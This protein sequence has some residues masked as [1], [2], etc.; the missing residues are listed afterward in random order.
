MLDD[1]DSVNKTL[2]LIWLYSVGGKQQANEINIKTRGW[3]SKLFPRF[4][5]SSL[6][7]SFWKTIGGEVQGGEENECEES[8]KDIWDS[9]QE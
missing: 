1:F 2:P 3:I 8:K 7:A 6:L 9:T 4:L 5:A